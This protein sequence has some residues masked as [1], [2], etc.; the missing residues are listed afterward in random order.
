MGI[1]T[2]ATLFHFS[3]IFLATTWPE[4]TPWFTY[5]VGT[6]V[7]LPYIQFMYLRNAYHFYSPEP[8]PAS[9]LFCLVTYE[10]TDPTTGQPLAD[11]VTH[12]SRKND[13]KDPLGLTYYRRLSLTEQVSNATPLVTQTEERKEIEARRL[14]VAQGL[15]P[16]IPAIPLDP[17]ENLSYRMPRP[18]TTRYLVPSYAAHLLNRY[19]TGGRVAKTVKIYR[20]EHTQLSAAQFVALKV[21]P[22]HPTGFKPFY[23]GEFQLNPDGTAEL[24]DQQDPMLYWHLPILPRAVPRGSPADTKDYDDYMSKHAKYE[25]NWEARTP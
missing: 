19:T 18:D 9:H 25:F 10:Q 17:N 21:D 7:H 4:P 5:Q 20:L 11:W 12:P 15:N 13:W 6:R 8:G 14:Q 24:V 23:L 2:A 3:G 16:K 22:H 1:I